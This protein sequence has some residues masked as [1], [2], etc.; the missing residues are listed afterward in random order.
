MLHTCS[1][2]QFL[3]PHLAELHSFMVVYAQNVGQKEM[4]I[5]SHYLKFSTIQQLVSS[6]IMSMASKK[7]LKTFL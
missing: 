2:W 5:P 3:G 7:G 1:S 6:C 4:P